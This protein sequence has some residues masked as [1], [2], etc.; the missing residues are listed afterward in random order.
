MQYEVFRVM[1]IKK[2]FNAKMQERLLGIDFD[3]ITN[4]VPEEQMKTK[5]TF[6]KTLDGMRGRGTGVK[7]DYWLMSDLVKAEEDPERNKQFVLTFRDANNRDKIITYRYEAET[8]KL[9]KQVVQKLNRLF[10]LYNKY[11]NKPN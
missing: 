10:E 3:R 7:H 9:A 8:P 4:Q 5:S 11:E 1:K 2:G 6:G